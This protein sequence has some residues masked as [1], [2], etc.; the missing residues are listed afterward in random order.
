MNSD[1]I[2]V[3]GEGRMLEFD[4]PDNLLKNKRSK[5]Y[6]LW[7]ESKEEKSKRMKS[8]GNIDDIK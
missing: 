3:M 5:F 1:K 8:I 7:K 4:T 2:L 6:G